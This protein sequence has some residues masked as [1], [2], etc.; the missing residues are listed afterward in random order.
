M[1]GNHM[2][3]KDTYLDNREW[4]HCH[5]CMS[6]HITDTRRCNECDEHTDRLRCPKCGEKSVVIWICEECGEEREE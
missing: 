1:E 2:I 6:H 4:P 5:K 3:Q